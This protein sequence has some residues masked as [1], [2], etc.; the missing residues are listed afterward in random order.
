MRSALLT[1]DRTK[2]EANSAQS[3]ARY[4]SVHVTSSLIFEFHDWLIETGLSVGT[5][6]R[7]EASLKQIF[8]RLPEDQVIRCG[9]LQQVREKLQK[10]GYAPT[11]INLYM[12]AANRLLEYCGHR[13]LQIVGDLPPDNAEQPELTRSEYLKLLDTARR[14]G[15]RREYLLVK[16]FATT[17]IAISE[18]S[19]L[20]VKA[21]RQGEF[22]V[23]QNNVNQSKHILPG[24]QTELIDYAEESGRRAGPIFI[25]KRGNAL[26]RNSIT[27][28][29]S[30]LAEPA[31]LPKEKCNPICLRKL[32]LTTR[33]EIADSFEPLINK[34]Y[35]DV[36]DKEQALIGWN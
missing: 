24:F 10:E 20:T 22:E 36:V 16:L 32:Y 3:A 35:D 12:C 1:Y 8:N 6:D 18:V 33:Q 13:E 19:K 29:I 23:C 34:T 25:S 15:K 31:G 9:T 17:G 27:I 7:Y 21:A 2:L 26:D 14:L 11:T 5:A 28:L 4:A 30:A